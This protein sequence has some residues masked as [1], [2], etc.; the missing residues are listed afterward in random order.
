[1]SVCVWVWVARVVVC[2]GVSG[3]VR[4][5]HTATPLIDMSHVYWSIKGHLSSFTVIQYVIKLTENVEQFCTIT[6]KVET[7]SRDDLKK[8]LSSDEDEPQF[9]SILIRCMAVCKIAIVK[10]PHNN[11][12]LFSR[13]DGSEENLHRKL[14]AIFIHY[15]HFVKIGRIIQI[16]REIAERC[17]LKFR[18]KC[19]FSP[20]YSF[21]CAVHVILVKLTRQFLLF[22]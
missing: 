22:S 1:M 14:Y 13:S 18:T 12:F 8:R 16:L 10:Y 4:L 21:W 6:V 19:A 2:M 15:R 7:A 3:C 9:V 20:S 11:S 17:Q 5:R